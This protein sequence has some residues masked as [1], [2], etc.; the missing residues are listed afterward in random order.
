LAEGVGRAR[1][2]ARSRQIDVAIVVQEGN[3]DVDPAV[4]RDLCALVPEIAVTSRR[5]GGARGLR[6]CLPGLSAILSKVTDPIETAFSASTIGSSQP[7]RVISRGKRKRSSQ[8]LGG[9]ERTL[10]SLAER[11]EA[12]E[13]LFNEI[14]LDSIR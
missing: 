9:C 3:G 10:L 7:R 6:D 4:F 11:L 13:D 12:G 1:D 2:L 14:E 5:N 8:S